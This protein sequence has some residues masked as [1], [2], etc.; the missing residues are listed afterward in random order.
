MYSHCCGLDIHK[1]LI[2]ACLLTLDEEGHFHKE[3]LSFGTMTHQI[4]ALGDW[5]A[6]KGCTHV[7]MESTGV[8]WKPLFNLLEGQFEL[9]VVNAHHLKT[10]P[11]RK[12][13]VRDAQWLAELLQHG[14]IRGSFIPAAPQR[15]LRELTRYRTCLVQERA[16]LFNR[17]QKVLEDGNIKLA[18]VVTDISGISA[19]A[20]LAQL[21]AGESDGTQLAQLAQGR[22]RNKR[23]E[24]ALALTGRIAEHQRFMLVQQLAHLDFL[25][26]QIAQFNG[27]IEQ[28]LELTTSLDA[29]AADSTLQP[30][31]GSALA[32]EPD[33][34]EAGLESI[35][36]E[37]EVKKALSYKQAVALL[38]SIPGVNQRIAEI[39][40]AEVG[41]DMEQFPSAQHLAS[42]A[43]MCPGN[44]QSAGKRLSGKT[45]KGS[46]WL[47]QALTQ[48]AQGAMHTKDSYLRTLGQRLSQRRGKKRAIVAVG[49]RILVIVYHILKSKKGYKELGA[50]FYDGR[51]REVLERK[52][53]GKLERLG[54]TVTL[55]PASD[56]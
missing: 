26:E 20:M 48:A 24:L 34:V 9:I 37:A 31:E 6:S 38:D 17:L 54:Y 28:R 10:V 14:L 13:D 35:A 23:E 21:A 3:I 52:L 7:V 49:H 41:L 27:E 19:R 1:K 25:D 4:L 16:R 30:P 2:V 42:W 5:L 29:A 50:D 56:G 44:H 39:I 43:G 36:A 51:Q 47:R 15:Q 40:L 12:T 55:Q 8:Y 45:R 32:S 53:V 22:L 11:G 18:S 46:V 33:K